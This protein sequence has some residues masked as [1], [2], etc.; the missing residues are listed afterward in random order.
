MLLLPDGQGQEAFS[1]GRSPSRFADASMEAA[2]VQRYLEGKNEG[3][4]DPQAGGDFAS[5]EGSRLASCIGDNNAGAAGTFCEPASVNSSPCGL[6]PRPP[7]PYCG[8]SRPF[9]PRGFCGR[10][11]SFRGGGSFLPL[12]SAG[13]RPPFPQCRPPQVPWA[14]RGQPTHW[15]RPF[16]PWLGAPTQ[17]P[18]LPRV[19]EPSGMRGFDNRP[20]T[21]YCAKNHQSGRVYNQREDSKVASFVLHQPRRGHDDTSTVKDGRER[22][23]HRPSQHCATSGQPCGGNET[24][25]SRKEFVMVG[26]ENGSYFKQRKR[27]HRVS[28]RSG[29][30][31]D[32]C[33][34][35]EGKQDGTDR[36]EYD[37]GCRA[38]GE[39]RSRQSRATSVAPN[40]A[41]VTANASRDCKNMR[42]ASRDATETYARTVRDVRCESS[43]EKGRSSKMGKSATVRAEIDMQHA[44]ERQVTDTMSKGEVGVRS[45]VTA[46]V[47]D[48]RIYRKRTLQDKRHKDEILAANEAEQLHERV[49]SSQAS[50]RPEGLPP[51]SRHTRAVPERRDKLRCGAARGSEVTCR[52]G[53][54]G[55]AQYKQKTDASRELPTKVSGTSSNS[56]PNKRAADKLDEE[57]NDA[58]CTDAEA[59]VENMLKLLRLQAA[60]QTDE[61]ARL[62]SAIGDVKKG[63]TCDP[64]PPTCLQDLSALPSL[65]IATENT[66]GAMQTST[67]HEATLSSP[68]A[69]D[70]DKVTGE[71]KSELDSTAGLHNCK[72][73]PSEAQTSHV[74]YGAP[75]LSGPT[76]HDENGEE[77]TFDKGLDEAAGPSSRFAGNVGP[78][79]SLAAF[80]RP[81]QDIT[82]AVHQ[83]LHS[84]FG[85]QM[86]RQERE[87]GSKAV[88]CTFARPCP[89]VVSLSSG[90]DGELE[91]E[92]CAS[93]MP[94]AGDEGEVIVLSES[95]PARDTASPARRSAVT[96]SSCSEDGPATTR[97]PSVKGQLLPL[98]PR[99]PDADSE[100]SLTGAAPLTK[101]VL[102]RLNAYTAL[103]VANLC[104]DEKAK[105]DVH[106][107]YALGTQTRAMEA[108]GAKIRQV[109]CA[110]VERKRVV[111]K[112]LTCV[113]RRLARVHWVAPEPGIGAGVKIQEIRVPPRYRGVYLD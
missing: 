74:V 40:Q 78:G 71:A 106:R 61:R 24:A 9:E 103:Y 48:P 81:A 58:A 52:S 102:F 21:P 35:H 39:S 4:S 13:P 66:S 80:V 51:S 111:F 14:A 77:E 46:A 65:R 83:W 16:T 49:S 60:R 100:R 29:D 6:L 43:A 15:G 41:R 2:E 33:G 99:Q 91:T 17:E 7:V 63:E 112:D 109:A 67:V 64:V 18:F 86:S 89:S 27:T 28:F 8:W 62:D 107:L 53:R 101:D 44:S 88:A 110:A 54:S 72:L 97:R 31:G 12:F 108:F 95:F 76:V 57:E 19:R 92:S 87:A 23:H 3:Y 42:C 22:R 26:D 36:A 75:P 96:I 45:R 94:D 25:T 5:G 47:A 73:Q 32:R 90:V 93:A 10:D 56:S 98:P 59:A 1:N 50:R 70:D 20:S 69:H 68:T 84:S 82:S 11:A 104:R 38:R 34:E 30:D 105:Q 79:D 85:D 55:V 113:M 37:V